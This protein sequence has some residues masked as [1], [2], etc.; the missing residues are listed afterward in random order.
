MPEVPKLGLKTL[1][2]K[3][4]TFWVIDMDLQLGTY[5]IDIDNLRKKVRK[6]KVPIIEVL[7]DEW[8]EEPSLITPGVNPDDWSYKYVARYIYSVLIQITTGEAQKA[9]RV[10]RDNNGF[11]ALRKIEE[12][13]SHLIT[14]PKRS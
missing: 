11:E 13:M 6:S 12:S 3:N 9:V 8:V 14:T 5:W 1:T 4:Y 10:T 7:Y 2:G